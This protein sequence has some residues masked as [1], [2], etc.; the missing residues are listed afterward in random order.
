M[1]GGGVEQLTASIAVSESELQKAKNLIQP[2]AK[3]VSWTD[4]ENVDT[5]TIVF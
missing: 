2:I 3:H 1:L 5:S 4:D